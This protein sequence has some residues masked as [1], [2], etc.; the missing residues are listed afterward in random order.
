MEHKPMQ[1]AG[2]STAQGP[3]P[4]GSAKGSL[5]TGRWTSAQGLQKHQLRGRRGQTRQ[6]DETF[7]GLMNPMVNYLI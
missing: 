1:P 5:E 6:E 4:I 7:S 3:L 2:I